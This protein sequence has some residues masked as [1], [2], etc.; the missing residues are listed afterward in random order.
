MVVDSYELV[1]PPKGVLADSSLTLHSHLPAPERGIERSR[2]ASHL[3]GERGWTS[4]SRA[5]L[6]T[7]PQSARQDASSSADGLRELASV[8]LAAADAAADIHFN[9]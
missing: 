3:Q 7:P 1:H 6:D 4:Q 5:R 2:S 8:N 9:E